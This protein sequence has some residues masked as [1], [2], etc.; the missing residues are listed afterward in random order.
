MTPV[1]MPKMGDGMEEG[2]LLEWGKKEGEKVKSGE[3]IGQIQT[4]KAV[5]EL[6]A[7]GSGI[8]KGIL[9]NEGETV[10]VGTPIAALV[11][12][13][14]ELPSNW[15]TNTE[16]AA[17]VPSTNGSKPSVEGT[18]PTSGG[19]T[20]GT[21]IQDLPEGFHTESAEM[22][23]QAPSEVSEGRIKASPLAKR[24]AKEKGIDLSTI[25]GSG[26]GGRIV[27]KDVA[28]AQPSGRTSA[29]S[30]APVAAQAVPSA[31]D[32]VVK[33]NRLR[34]ITGQRTLQSKQQIPHFYVRVEV[35]VDKI[36]DLRKMFEEEGSGKVSVNDFVVK[37]CAAALQEMPL[38]N[39]VFQGDSVLQHGAVHIGLAVALEDGLTVP[40][41]K[42]AHALSLRQISARSKEL[43]GKAR[44]NKLHPDELSGSTFSIS[45]MGM[46]DI[47]DF[48]AIINQPNSAI[49]A[50]STA[51]KRVVV[52]ENDE[53]EIRTMM[54]VT[55]SF[56]HR[57]VDGAVGARF[58]NLVK[59]YLE[60]PTRLLS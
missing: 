60:S 36:L 20:E 47:D 8:L 24:I 35:N 52:N 44:E 28:E 42:N 57:V 29:P 50:V 54:N 46:L 22:A 53:L 6:E 10:P 9:V 13:G 31:E 4:D 26:P 43:A 40:V 14:E 18:S 32:Q 23:H 39:A 59:G 49:L 27:E 33:L 11:K 2:T 1:I 34:Q 41:I 56:D 37:A 38:V 5:L 19:S 7:P 17:D 48:I 45:N 58:I 30:T 25:Q 12:E 51:R 16:S 21:G 55:C 15:G 3:I